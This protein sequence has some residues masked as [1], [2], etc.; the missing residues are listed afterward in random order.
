MKLVYTICL[1]LLVTGCSENTQNKESQVTNKQKQEVVKSNLPVKDKA[2]QTPEKILSPLEAI[3]ELDRKIESYKTGKNLTPE[4]AASNKQLKQ[5]IIRGTF[6]IY[7]LCR[8]ALDVH[9]Q[10]R[11]DQERKEFSELMTSLLE[12]K[13]IF[14]KEQVKGEGSPYKIQY[15][16]EQYLTAD[17]TKA[18]V[19][20]SINVP[21]EKIT[22]EINYHLKL[23]DKGWRIYDVIVDEASLVENYKFQFNTIIQKY[24]YA[25]L[26]TR[27]RS[28]LE[29]MK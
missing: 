17:K 21:S 2:E 12:K 9:W 1:I 20:S 15:K 25:D 22:L 5:D 29:K 24:G 3:K 23:T 14:S 4:E 6:D 8:L 19:S 28:K 10:D 27:M 11:T 7:E 13:A 26:V 16:K 18:I